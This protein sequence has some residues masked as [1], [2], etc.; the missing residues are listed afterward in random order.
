MLVI[1]FASDETPVPVVQVLISAGKTKMLRDNQRQKYEEK[2]SGKG[3]VDMGH[4][5]SWELAAHTIAD[6][7]ESLAREYE[8]VRRSKRV[9]PSTESGRAAKEPAKQPGKFQQPNVKAFSSCLLLTCLLISI[10]SGSR[11]FE[12]IPTST[13]SSSSGGDRHL[14]QA[15][16]VLSASTS[17]TSGT[18]GEDSKSCSF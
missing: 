12:G 13:A 1:S 11:E 4:G 9:T 8:I 15:S 14:Q 3:Y 6:P 2:R 10:S 5:T 16:S 17:T 18:E 7:V